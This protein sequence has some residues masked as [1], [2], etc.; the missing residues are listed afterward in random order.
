LPISQ[1]GIGFREATLVALL[2]PFGPPAA[3]TVAAGLVWEAIA[4]SGGLAGGLFL[5][6]AGR[7]VR[8]ARFGG[9]N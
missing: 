9:S 4:I 6:L 3:L 7:F 2:L 5:F 1:E 8:D